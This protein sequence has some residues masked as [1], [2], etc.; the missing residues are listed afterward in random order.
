MADRTPPTTDERRALAGA[1]DRMAEE[2]EAA[3]A[4]YP[5]LGIRSD[6]AALR[7]AAAILRE[8]AE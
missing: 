4:A 2:R 8:G 5:K 3:L 7:R 1:L 6:T